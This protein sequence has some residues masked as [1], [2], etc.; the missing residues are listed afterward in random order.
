MTKY[1]RFAAMAVIFFAL[2][3]L[4]GAA[5][6]IHTIGYIPHQLANLRILF[7]APML[8]ALAISLLV[9]K[10]VKEQK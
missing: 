9:M 2:A 1:I 3:M 5:D 8:I 4:A 10:F 6:S 7:S